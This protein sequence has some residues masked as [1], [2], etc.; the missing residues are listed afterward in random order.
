MI[1]DAGNSTGVP[2]TANSEVTA[3][4]P[5]NERP[6]DSSNR[7]DLSQY[8][9][10]ELF[11]EIAGLLNIKGAFI[12]VAVGFLI[13]AIGAAVAI[14]LILHYSELTVVP[15]LVLCGYALVV[16][17][18]AAVAV[19]LLRIAIGAMNNIDSILKLVIR[20]TDQAAADQQK[21]HSGEMQM[22][23]GP[24]LSRRIFDEVVSV[25][26]DKVVSSSLGFLATP[27][28][29]IYRK[30]VGVMV[31]RFLRRASVSA[32]SDAGPSQLGLKTVAKVAAHSDRIKRYT[33]GASKLVG[34]TAKVARFFLLGPMFVLLGLAL[35]VASIP[36]IWIVLW[37]RGG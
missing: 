21:I 25:G 34:G 5:S 19:S 31:N 14:W 24:K 20:L 10:P 32:D 23:S 11:E 13:A 35:L 28:K 37:S 8:K 9:T 4:D 6:L 7:F 15:S 30:T 22:L 33:Q 2:E 18:V 36:V 26:I 1:S 12:K 3:N 16:S 27:V 17:V 29:W